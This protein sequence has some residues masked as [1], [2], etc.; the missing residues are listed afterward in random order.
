MRVV[1]KIRF[2]TGDR[3]AHKASALAETEAAIV[4]F[5]LLATTPLSACANLRTMALLSSDRRLLPSN[6]TPISESWSSKVVID[7]Q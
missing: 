1:S 6:N 2:E 7:V 5:L 4:F 3:I